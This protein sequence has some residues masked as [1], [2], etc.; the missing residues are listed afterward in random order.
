[1]LIDKITFKDLSIFVADEEEQSVFSKLNL[2]TTNGGR[3]MLRSLFE[4]P[5]TSKLA[6]ENQQAVL[7]YLAIHQHQMPLLITNGS[8]LMIEKFFSTPVDSIPNH[9]NAM[10]AANY[11][12]MHYNDYALIKFSI[13]HFVDF[14]QGMY[15]MVTQFLD[16][17]PIQLQEKLI[18]IQKIC[19]SASIAQQI[20][21]IEDKKKISATDNLNFA[22]FFRERFKHETFELLDMYSLFD[23][24]M[25]MALAAQ[26][27]NLNYP[28]LL[29]I[30]NA[31]VKGN[32]VFHAMLS[33]PVSYD[34][35][36]KQHENFIFL[37][38]ANM[39]GKSTFIKAVGIAVYLAHLG[40]AVPAKDFTLSYMD[41]LLSNIQVADNIT[42]G[43]SYFFNEVQRIKN[44][45][46]KINNNKKWL[47]LIDE[48]FKGTNV[49][50]AMKCSSTVI[51]GLIKIPNS[52]FILSTHLYE[53][54]E[55]LKQ[56]PNINFKYFETFAHNDKL[57]FSYLLKDGIS[58]DRLGYLILKRE[59]VVD[60]LEN[61]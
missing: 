35:E 60:I 28:T 24:W 44:T 51:K 25:S 13:T 48:L 2:T 46:E 27:F 18:R 58:N 7:Q 21:A 14:I 38:G 50:D 29:D 4:Q 26:K 1:M 39:A 12:V 32:G 36:L 40:M 34:I 53:I 10:T 19:T 57:E 52:L 3:A 31:Y 61:L 59:G 6:I 30:E 56:Y 33:T 11:K 49:Q 9:A 45:V 5:L 41:G 42:K 22:Y 43:E 8:I 17:A 37:T 54:G 47:V 55:E 16:T 20:I 15:Q 23:A